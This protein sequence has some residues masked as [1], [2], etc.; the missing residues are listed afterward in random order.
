GPANPITT[1]Q[2]RVGQGTIYNIIAFDGVNKLTLATPYVDP[3]QG[4]GTGYQILG[5]YYNAPTKDFLWFESVRDPVSGYTL[6]TIMTRE[7]VDDIDPQRFQ[8]GWPQAVIPYAINQQPGAF[9]GFPQFEMWPAPLNNY[10]YVATG[11]RAGLG[12]VNTTDVQPPQIGDDVIVALAKYYGYQFCE[13]NKDK[14]GKGDFRYL[15]GAAMK[16]YMTLLDV[17]QFRDEEFSHRHIIDSPTM[18]LIT[19]LPWVSM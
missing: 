5:I 4:A 12:F 18:N 10:T 9:Y 15:M 17:Y 16:E 8:S 19:G 3:L 6:D 13:A 1:R 2:F 14:T 7:T 11:F